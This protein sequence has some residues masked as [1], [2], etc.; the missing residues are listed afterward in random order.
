MKKLIK[1]EMRTRFSLKLPPRILMLRV[2]PATCVEM[3]DK[4]GGD[5]LPIRSVQALIISLRYLPC[6]SDSCQRALEKVV[7][8]LRAHG[9]PTILIEAN[10]SVKANLVRRRLL[11]AIGQNSYFD[12]LKAARTSCYWQESN[13][14]N[15]RPI[16][17]GIFAEPLLVTSLDYFETGYLT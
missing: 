6:I 1:I 10:E 15:L 4:I 3:L 17:I 8:K 13:I 12:D 11:E 16:V 2:E 7:G 5:I 14:G 9:V